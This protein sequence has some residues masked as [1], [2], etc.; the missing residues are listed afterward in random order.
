MSGIK[1]RSLVVFNQSAFLGDPP[2]APHFCYCCQRNWWVVV[3]RVQTGVSITDAVHSHSVDRWALS[4]AGLPDLFFQKRPNI[5]KKLQKKAKHSSKNGQ[6]K[7]FKSRRANGQFKSVRGNQPEIRPY[8]QN[9]AAK[10]SIRQPME[11]SRCP[12][13]MARRARDSVAPLRRSSAG[14]MPARIGRLS[15]GVGR[16]HPVTI[17]KASLM[18]G[19]MRRVWA[20]RHQTA[21][22][23]SAVEWTRARLAV[24]NVVA[25]APHQAASIRVR[26]VMS[27][28]CEVTQGVGDTW[29]TCPTLLQ[30]ILAWNRRVSLLY[31]TLSSRL[32]SLLLRW[33]AADTVSAVLSFCFQVW[34]YSPSVAMSLLS[35]LP[36]PASL[37]QCASLLDR[38]HMHTFWRRWL[39]GQRCRCWREGAPGQIPV[40][41]VLEAS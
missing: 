26:R 30:G 37:N 19:S 38:Q 40:G 24:R 1:V 16:R 3:R 8:F 7:P 15:A 34:R 29:A 21:T 14:W 18:A 28:S 5:A 6:K 39:A 41:H 35:T 10:R 20:L 23:Y 31:L 2:R 33:K 11:W 12:G 17:R 13:S 32:A 25:P 9:L 36:L 22:Q 27:A 4:G